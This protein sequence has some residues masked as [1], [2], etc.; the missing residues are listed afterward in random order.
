MIVKECISPEVR[1]YVNQAL[2]PAEELIQN[3][4]LRG[5]HCVISTSDGVEIERLCFDLKDPKDLEGQTS[6]FFQ[7]ARSRR[8]LFQMKHN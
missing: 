3:G 8:S 4:Q 6:S 1:D 5:V 2:K 7:H